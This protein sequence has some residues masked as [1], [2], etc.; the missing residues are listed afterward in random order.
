MVEKPSIYLDMSAEDNLKEQYRVIGLPSFDDI[1]ELLR[2][3]GLENT[4]I[5][6]AKNFSLG[7][8]Q[9]VYKRQVHRP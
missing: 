5:K 8:K 7:M 9:D 6:K 2:L 1:P 3:V 4:G